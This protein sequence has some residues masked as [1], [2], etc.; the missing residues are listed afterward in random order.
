[1]KPKSL[2]I[3]TI[4]EACRHDAGDTGAEG[5]GRHDLAKSLRT[6]FEVRHDCRAERRYDHEV[7][8][9]NVRGVGGGS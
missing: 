3:E 1:M 4:S 7:K 6:D 8:D 5:V 9:R 2:S